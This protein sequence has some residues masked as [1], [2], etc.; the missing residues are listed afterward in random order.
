MR[1][2]LLASV[3]ALPFIIVAAC[4][5]DDPNFPTAVS[6]DAGPA[7]TTTTT[8]TGTSSSSSSGSSTSS[9]SGSTSGDSATPA[10]CTKITVSTLAGNGDPGSTNGTGPDARFNG[11]E[12]ITVNPAD[13]T[14]YVG[15]LKNG[16]IRSVTPEGGVVKTYLN[17]GV[18]SVKRLVYSN[19]DIFA[20]NSDFMVRV[21]DTP[22]AAESVVYSG[23]IAVAVGPAGVR[24]ATGTTFCQV[25]SSPSGANAFATFSGVESSSDCGFKDG[26]KAT[27]RY[28]HSIV[29]LLFDDTDAANWKLFIADD[30]NHRVR[31]LDKAGTVQ[32]FAGSDTAKHADGKGTAASF[33]KLGG[34]AFDKA[35]RLLYVSDGTRIRRITADGDV[36]TLTGG[37]TPGFTD[38]DGC[39]AK[40]GAPQGIVYDKGALFVVDTNRIRKIVLP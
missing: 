6:N 34:L 18:N 3:A 10:E 11:A 35:H 21:T 20:T 4:V 39:K 33:T 7:A 17:N 14:L 12:G 27:A 16:A 19:G 13:G 23:I 36:T 32:T 30:G 5:G 31:V 40:F 22:S 28:S 29:D 1:T 8:G 9:S 24:Y 26:D 25:A 38:G 37:D 15:D 2:Y